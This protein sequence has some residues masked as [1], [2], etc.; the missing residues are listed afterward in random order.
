MNGRYTT[1]ERE[2]VGRVKGFDELGALNLTLGR[3]L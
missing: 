3:L 2:H 1:A